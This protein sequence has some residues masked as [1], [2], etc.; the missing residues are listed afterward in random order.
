MSRRVQ[1][2]DE[3]AQAICNFKGAYNFKEVSAERI[4]YN[5]SD[6]H[7]FGVLRYISKGDYTHKAIDFI[8]DKGWTIEFGNTETEQGLVKSM[9][10][11][12]FKKSPPDTKGIG[13]ISHT[14]LF[15]VIVKAAEHIFSVSKASTNF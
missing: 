11:I 7:A 12:K 4:A 2:N 5:I 15:E 6:R 1:I 13:F 9:V 14:D 3:C 8:L 10:T